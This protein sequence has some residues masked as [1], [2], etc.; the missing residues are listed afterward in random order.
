M[1]SKSPRI[2][3]LQSNLYQTF[4]LASLDR[5]VEFGLADVIKSAL[6]FPTLWTLEDHGLGCDQVRGFKGRVNN[7]EQPGCQKSSHMQSEVARIAS[8]Q[9]LF[10]GKS[11]QIVRRRVSL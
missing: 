11:L 8:T 1:V 2:N 4:G 6:K 10:L 3:D 7:R 5:R 9:T